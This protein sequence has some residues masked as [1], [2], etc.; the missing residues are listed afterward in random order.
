MRPPGEPGLAEA[1]GEEGRGGA[2]AL[3]AAGNAREVRADKARG[4]EARSGVN[5]GA[6]AGRGGELRRR[7]HRRRGSRESQLAARWSLRGLGAPNCR[8]HSGHT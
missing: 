6:G 1:P 8:W 7:S 5:Q 4:G 2:L 3:T